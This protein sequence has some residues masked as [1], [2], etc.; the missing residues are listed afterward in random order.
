MRLRVVIPLGLLV[1]VLFSVNSI[2]DVFPL[3][4]GVWIFV[5]MWAFLKSGLPFRK[6]VIGFA[7][8]LVCVIVVV[9]LAFVAPVKYEDRKVGPLPNRS[10]T[11]HQVSDFLQKKGLVKLRYPE[12]MADQKMLFGKDIYK[13]RDL[14]SE[15]ERQTNSQIGIGY[16]GN[17]IS[18]LWG[19][20][21]PMGIRLAR[22]S[23]QATPSQSR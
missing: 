17:A 19:G 4:T 2:M 12:D 20:Q 15:I 22:K 18:V 10:M 5:L 14:F 9:A 1:G 7:A 13:V 8:H 23:E 11:L 16:C 21:W 3:G 6:R